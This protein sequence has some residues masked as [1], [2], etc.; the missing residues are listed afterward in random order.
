MNSTP[1]ESLHDVQAIVELYFIK[2]DERYRTAFQNIWKSIL[3]TDRHNTG[4]FGSGEEATGNPYDPRPIETCATVAWM[5]ANVD[6]LRLSGDPR[7]A[8]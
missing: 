2:G 3:S 1:R 8:G 4:G 6:M 7:A 5:A